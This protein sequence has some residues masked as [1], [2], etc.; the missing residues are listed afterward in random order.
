MRFILKKTVLQGIALF[1]FLFFPANCFS[2]DIKIDSEIISVPAYDGFVEISKISPDTLAMFEDM[3]PPT[4]NLHAVFVT[5]SDSAKLLKYQS[6]ELKRYLIVQTAKSLESVALGARHFAELRNKIRE[7]YESLFDQNKSKIDELAKR[8]SQKLSDRISDNFE[9]KVGEMLPMSVNSETAYHISLSS[10][11]KYSTSTAEGNT[12]FIS[13]GTMSMVLLKGRVLYLNVFSTYNNIEDLKWT[14]SVA[15]KW[16]ESAVRSNQNNTQSGLGKI[17]PAGTRIDPEVKEVL[18]AE[19]TTFSTLGHTKSQGLN[20]SLKYPST[21][22]AREGQR[23]HIVQKFTGAS[24]GSIVPGCMVIIQELPSIGKIFL[25]GQM[26]EEI[27]SEGVKDYIPPG[28]V[29]IDGGTTKIDAEP[30]AWVKY[31]FEQDTSGVKVGMYSLQYMLFYKGSMFALQCS[32]AGSASEKIILEDA[33][34]SYLPVFQNIGSSI[35]IPDKWNKEMS[36]TGV[37]SSVM[38][39]TYG[40]NWLLTLLFSAILTWG[41]GLAPPLLIRFAFIKH[42]LSKPPALITVIFLWV[43]NFVIFTALGSESKTHGALL[44]VAWASYAIL[45]KGAAKYEAEQA[46]HREEE[47]RKAEEQR[48]KEE[49]RRRTEEESRRKKEKENEQKQ[50]ENSN[51]ERKSIKDEEYYR[52]ILGLGRTFTVEDI[53]RRYRELVAKYHPDK[54]NHLG[55]KLKEMA[56]R[57]MKEINEAY[58]YFKKKYNFK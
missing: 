44:L 15:E 25:D 32:I 4:N 1:C 27:F 35:Y 49:E 24:T 45:R 26:A 43:F 17:V 22:V 40:E 36:N 14:Q 31:Y 41:V 7:E 10:L 19:K 54:V 2:A 51:R 12:E 34:S 57:E 37:A 6:P 50:H 33:F 55:E 58:E 5:A 13:A 3:L 8:A 52:N 9:M 56:E 29:Y 46:R 38:K 48:I 39:D 21:W 16:T 42:A 23:P 47:N 28:A 53:K 11:T 30:G 20:I 18:S